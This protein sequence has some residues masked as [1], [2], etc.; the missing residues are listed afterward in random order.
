MHT[1]NTDNAILPLTLT[2][3]LY[4]FKLLSF[5]IFQIMPIILFSVMS[6]CMIES[7]K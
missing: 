4:K 6:L 5:E 7:Q 3:P 2:V 1:L